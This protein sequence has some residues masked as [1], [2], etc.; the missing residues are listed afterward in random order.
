VL[1]QAEAVVVADNIATKAAGYR[2]RREFDASLE[3]YLDM[4]AG[5]AAGAE[6]HFYRSPRGGVRIRRPSRRRH[7]D[8]VLFERRSLR[9]LD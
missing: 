5:R 9:Q 1:A 2:P 6:G 3:Y 7:R 4:G 8:K